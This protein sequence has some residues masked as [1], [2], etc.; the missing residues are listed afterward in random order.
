MR[1]VSVMSFTATIGLMAIFAVDLVDML[2]I[3][4]L[5]NEALAAAVGYAGTLLFF[6]TSIAIGFSIAAGALVAKSLGSHDVQS[7]REFASSVL[8]TGLIGSAVIVVAVLFYKE[9]LLDLLGA[10]GETKALASTFLTIVVPSMPVMVT[11][12]VASA[13]LRAH[14]D[15][16]RAMLATLCAGV[17]NAVLD[18]LFIFGFGWGFEGAAIASVCSRIALLIAALWPA[19]RVYNGFVPLHFK[20]LKRDFSA[21]T[22][23]AAP[24]VLANVATPIGA[25]IVTREM[26]KFGTD[27]IAGMAL[28]GR[29]TPV[30]FAV[31]FALSGAVGPIIGQ[32]H[33][34]GLEHRVRGTFTASL[35]FALIYTLFA[36]L[37]LYLFRD[38][39]ASVFNA[40]GD[41]LMLL[42][43]FCGPLALSYFFNSVIFV[44]N[45]AFNNLGHP[46]YSTLINWGKNTIGTLPFVMVG[47]SYWG[48]S[49]VL[50]GQAMGSIIFAII[51]LLLSVKVMS[52]GQCPPP[53][54]DFKKHELPH[55][56]HS[57]NH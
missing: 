24:A 19:I 53:K 54:N 10:T 32:N 7:A 46:F 29:I 48:A 5:G 12:M 2:F 20:G 21:V 38:A 40:S 18:P 39:I 11:A 15:A 42:L 37:L 33:G 3:S 47:A 22:G 51:A 50:I 14:G 45:A 9:A 52:T 28:I 31:V 23:I 55:T 6:T 17:V 26:A 41:S 4:M 27:A 25:A 8:L 57:R 1:H 43:L 35:K 30:A 13:V 34:A 49:G 56:L 16:K 44:G 36:A